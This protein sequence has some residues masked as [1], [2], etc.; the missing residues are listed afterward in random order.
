MVA[1]N[2]TQYHN[3]YDKSTPILA[4]NSIYQISVAVK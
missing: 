2:V 1:D 3:H 4:I